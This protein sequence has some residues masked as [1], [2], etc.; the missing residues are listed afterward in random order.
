MSQGFIEDLLK[1]V[2]SAFLAF[3]R[4]S[5]LSNTYKL[6]NYWQYSFYAD[7]RILG[8]LLMNKIIKLVLLLVA[9]CTSFSYANEG[10][11]GP[12]LSLG[13]NWFNFDDERNLSDEEDFYFGGG[14]QTSEHL[15]F[16]FRYTDFE[17]K[18]YNIST[19]YRYQP[20]SVNSFY[21][22]AGLGKYSD[23]PG[24][25]TNLNLGAGYE[26]HFN[27]TISLVFGVDSVYQFDDAQVDWVPYVGFNFFFGGSSQ[28]SIPAPTPQPVKTAPLDSDKDG[29][30]DSVD[31]CP[32]TTTGVVVDSN[33]C[34]LDSDNDGVAD[35]VDQCP[36]TPTGA[37]VDE[38]GC[39]I[40]LTEDV[41]IKLSVQFANNSDIVS[42]NYASEIK[43]VA[44]FMNSY[45]D[46]SVVI[47]GHT[48]S[49]GAA[50]YNQSLSQ[51]RATAV[52]QFLVSRFGVDQSRVS[53]K[54]VGEVSPIASNDSAEGRATNRRV[55]AE[56][57]TSVSKPQ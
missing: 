38:K 50:S 18:Y 43:K 33:G 19:I 10:E 20:R 6:S 52:M 25:N 29:I 40:I 32:D 41:S 57:K 7:L 44:D 13:H 14:Y 21:W 23:L 15:G 42:D 2:Q 1:Y 45:P 55:Q 39:R 46:T 22:K 56:I 11:T 12:Y 51:K 34:E 54:G 3:L 53:A 16:E 27:N 31:Q 37:K 35:S 49:R 5:L 4:C 48:D 47:E 28:K 8:L 17:A 26:A 9:C 36:T 24:G 30:F